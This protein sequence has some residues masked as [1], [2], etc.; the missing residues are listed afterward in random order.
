MVKYGEHTGLSTK[1]R[2]ITLE[3]I[4][5]IVCDELKIEK[6]AIRKKGRANSLESFARQLYY[7][8]SANNTCYSYDHIAEYLGHGN[9]ALNMGHTHVVR[10]KVKIEGIIYKTE[11]KRIMDERHECDLIRRCMTLII[12]EGYA[13][14]GA[15]TPGTLA[16]YYENIAQH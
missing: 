2:A 4:E 11:V 16:K 3:R 14:K 1:Y 9:Q 13:I 8:L 6:T 12:E 15:T 5:D 10:A 7:F